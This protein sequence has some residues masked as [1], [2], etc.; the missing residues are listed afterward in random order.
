MISSVSPQSVPYSDPASPGP[1][2]RRMSMESSDGGSRRPLDGQLRLPKFVN[3]VNWT[4]PPTLTETIEFMRLEEIMKSEPPLLS[5]NM[6]PT[7]STKHTDGDEYYYIPNI[8]REFTA[9]SI[10]NF[11]NQFIPF[12]VAIFLPRVKVLSFNENQKG[13]LKS[14]HSGEKFVV[15]TFAILNDRRS[16]RQSLLGESLVA[17]GQKSP[18]E[19]IDTIRILNDVYVFFEK[20]FWTPIYTQQ[21]SPGETTTGS[22]SSKFGGGLSKR[23][24]VTNSSSSTRF[25]IRIPTSCASSFTEDDLKRRGVVATEQTNNGELTA[26]KFS[27]MEIR[28]AA[29]DSF[30]LAIEIFENREIGLSRINDSIAILENLKSDKDLLDF[31]PLTSFYPPRSLRPPSR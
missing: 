28:D 5:T 7:I 17:Y 19:R 25:I 14:F 26:L 22:L 10:Q 3:H 30:I 6:T 18:I 13:V 1:E 27:R 8:P 15:N 11:A 16:Y 29:C 21:P 4:T 31:P 20:K 12:P 2:S 23:T 9:T 24:S